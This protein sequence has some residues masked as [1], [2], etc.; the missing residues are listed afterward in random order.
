MTFYVEEVPDAASHTPRP[1]P[2]KATTLTAAKREA[3]RARVFKGT[4][5]VVSDDYGRRAFKTGAGAWEDV[6]E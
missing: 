6:T 5:L 4:V 3:T 2:L 1:T